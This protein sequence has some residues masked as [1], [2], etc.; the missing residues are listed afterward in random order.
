MRW[1]LAMT[2]GVFLVASFIVELSVRDPGYGKFW[3]DKV[4]GFYILFGFFGGVAVILISRALAKYV[5]QR[6]E[7]YYQ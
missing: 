6:P 2:C 5:L 1:W 3:W 4:P 7:D